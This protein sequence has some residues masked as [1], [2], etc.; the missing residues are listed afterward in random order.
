MTLIDKYYFNIYSIDYIN[1]GLF[2]V[3]YLLSYE[4]TSCTL[5]DLMTDERR[6]TLKLFYKTYS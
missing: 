6:P 1:G 4:H 3:T 2:Y 5:L